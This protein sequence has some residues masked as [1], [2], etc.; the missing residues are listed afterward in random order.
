MMFRDF[1]VAEDVAKM[2]ELRRFEEEY[3]MYG[4]M[5]LMDGKP[6]Y[7][8]SSREEKIVGFINRREN[9]LKFPFPVVKYTLRTTVPSGAEEDIVRMV[10]INLAKIIRN[11]YP[12]AFLEAFYAVALT[13]PDDAAKEPLD[14]LQEK[15]Y[16]MYRAENLL[17]FEG[18]MDLAYRAKHITEKNRAGYESW[19]NEEW[20]QMED[21]PVL[22]DQFSKELYGFAYRNAG[23]IKA[24]YN[25]EKAK[26]YERKL[27]LEAKGILVS[28]VYS[29]E[30]WYN[31]DKTLQDVRSEFES[32]LLGLFD[33]KYFHYLQKIV[34]LPSVICAEELQELEKQY[35]ADN[36]AVQE[37]IT[38]Y[39]QYW[40]IK[41]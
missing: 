15:M 39:K 6:N 35:A 7:I 8:I 27:Q 26:V 24:V 30:C 13:E 37:V 14:T 9:Y 32:L 22:K 18:L 2:M 36:A 5:F 31:Y 41:E 16:G 33:E 40:G 23:C 21:D 10:K 19:L 20:H 25:A 28:Q 17:L 12:K 1:K 29:K 11:S 3:T 4:S 34:S 38:T